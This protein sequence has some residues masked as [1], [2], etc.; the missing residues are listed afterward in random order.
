MGEKMA[1]MKVI[2]MCYTVYVYGKVYGLKCISL[3]IRTIQKVLHQTEDILLLLLILESL[4]SCFL[5]YFLE[6]ETLIFFEMQSDVCSGVRF[7]GP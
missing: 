5:K 6:N 4:Y 2:Y 3:Y 1:L 7:F